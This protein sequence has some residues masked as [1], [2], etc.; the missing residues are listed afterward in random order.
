MYFSY[1]YIFIFL[2][3]VYSSTCI[4]VHLLPMF[5]FVCGFDTFCLVLYSS[6]CI[7]ASLGRRPQHFEQ[8][9]SFLNT[10]LSLLF[11]V[12]LQEFMLGL[13]ERESGMSCDELKRIRGWVNARTEPKKQRIRDFCTAWH[14]RVEE[15]CYVIVTLI[16]FILRV[17]AEFWMEVLG[18]WVHIIG[19]N[20]V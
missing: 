19:M 3:D 15:H 13:S 14:E 17:L 1:I 5:M 11:V 7:T 2:L 10:S 16:T 4:Q 18:Y 8:G 9:G 12:C 6:D 20:T